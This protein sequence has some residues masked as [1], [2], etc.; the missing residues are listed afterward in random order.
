MSDKEMKDEYDFSD[1]ERGKFYDPSARYQIPV[2]LESETF[3]FVEEIARR[4]GSDVS[5]V[6]NDLIQADR[7]LFKRVQ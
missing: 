7:E 6:V 1:A 3:E 4:K 5:S 2:Y